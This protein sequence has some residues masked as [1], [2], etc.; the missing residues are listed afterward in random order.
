MSHAPAQYP[1]GITG[2][3]VIKCGW[4]FQK[5]Q[6][7]HGVSKNIMATFPGITFFEMPTGFLCFVRYRLDTI[8]KT[9]QVFARNKKNTK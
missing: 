4:A 3:K 1:A 8:E 5:L 9:G 6:S 2:K 7:A